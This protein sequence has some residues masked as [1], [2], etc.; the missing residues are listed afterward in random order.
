MLAARQPPSEAHGL[1]NAPPTCRPVSCANAPPTCCPVSC[2]VH[3][4]FS[5]SIAKRKR[6]WQPNRISTCA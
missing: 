5:D 1:A 2:A 6:L 3:G 4:R